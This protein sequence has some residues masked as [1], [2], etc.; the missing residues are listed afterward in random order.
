MK[1]TYVYDFSTETLD[2][3]SDMILGRICHGIYKIEDDIYALTGN[4]NYEPTPKNEVYNLTD[5]SWSELNDLPGVGISQATV[6]RIAG[7][8][9]IGGYDCTSIYVFSLST[10]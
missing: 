10:K 7:N 8:L 6:A 3:Q 1:N 5:D 9:Y 2:R 4:T